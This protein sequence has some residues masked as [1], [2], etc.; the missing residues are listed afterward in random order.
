ML[1]DHAY[2]YTIKTGSY[3]LIHHTDELKVK[4]GTIR[5][6]EFVDINGRVY[7]DWIPAIKLW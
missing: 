3:P 4:S 7:N 2:N 6:T 1:P 5:C